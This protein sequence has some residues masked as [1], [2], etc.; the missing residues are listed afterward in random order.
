MS[1]FRTRVRERAAR[2]P[3]AECRLAA[4]GLV[5]GHGHE[6]VVPVRFDAFNLFNHPQPANPNLNI[7]GGTTFGNIASKSENRVLQG[8]LRLDF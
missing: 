7:N 1:Y 5:V 3:G 8:Q 4:R 6:Q 2:E